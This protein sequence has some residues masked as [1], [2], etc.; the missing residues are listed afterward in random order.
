MF[1]QTT[2]FWLQQ[3]D[4][5]SRAKTTSISM[6]V[7]GSTWDYSGAET[8]AAFKISLSNRFQPL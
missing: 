4:F 6:H 7:K 8:Q 5:G 1:P 2:I 3:W